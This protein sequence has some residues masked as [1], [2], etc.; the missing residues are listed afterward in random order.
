MYQY[1]YQGCP[2]WSWYFPYHY[3]PFCSD[4]NLI[5]K[6]EDSITKHLSHNNALRPA[7]EKNTPYLPFE[8]L[9]SVLPAKSAHA[10]PAGLRPLLTEPETS[11]IA[12]FYPS[13]IVLDMNGHRHSWK[14]VNLIPFIDST[15]LRAA[16]A[17]RTPL[18]TTEEEERNRPGFERLFFAEQSF[19]ASDSLF[20]ESFFGKLSPE[21]VSKAGGV[22]CFRFEYPEYRKHI[23]R[24]LPS[25]GR[26]SA[27]SVVSDYDIENMDRRPFYGDNAI[28]MVKRALNISKLPE[29]P[30]YAMKGESVRVHHGRAGDPRT[31][32]SHSYNNNRGFSQ[33]P[34]LHKIRGR[35]DRPYQGGR[36]ARE[37]SRDEERVRP[38]LPTRPTEQESEDPFGSMDMEALRRVMGG[39][40]KEE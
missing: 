29:K 6:G 16:V 8:Q 36:F 12:D 34:T 25:A 27:R 22:L 21:P 18:L 23:P 37:R 26:T 14:G 38:P 33:V 40:K 1:Y 20:D 24:L 39:G 30:E 35:D 13:D 4:L 17:E 2:S 3:A 15:R 7:L 19:P 9:M 11:E 32:F 5:S 31:E 10:L 28:A